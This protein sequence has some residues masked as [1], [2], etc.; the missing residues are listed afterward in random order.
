MRLNRQLLLMSA[1]LGTLYLTYLACHFMGIGTLT[2]TEK[3]AR[4]LVFAMVLPHMLCMGTAIVFNW[5]GWVLHAPWAA[6]AAGLLYGASALFAMIYAPCVVIELSLCIIGYVRMKQQNE[7]PS[8]KP[9]KDKK[10]A[11]SFRE[12]LACRTNM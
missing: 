3:L 12:G 9:M 5:I 10:T 7:Q 11:F 6:L 4:E 2:P 1:G 8:V